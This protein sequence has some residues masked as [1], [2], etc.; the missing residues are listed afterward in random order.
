MGQARGACGASLLLP[1]AWLRLPLQ[2]DYQRIRC[3]QRHAGD[4]DAGVWGRGVAQ[5]LYRVPLPVAEFN[6]QPAIVQRRRPSGQAGDRLPR[7]V[8][9]AR[10]AGV[11]FGGDRVACCG[12]AGGVPVGLRVPYIP[13]HV[14]E[15]RT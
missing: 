10:L 7:L 6:G 8:P 13:F 4:D 2:P 3:V 11:V 9:I 14:R 15:P 1:P 12:D 5:S